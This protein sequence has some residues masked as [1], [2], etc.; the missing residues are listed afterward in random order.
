V[1][2]EAR[3][4]IPRSATARLDV[5]LVKG[6]DHRRLYERILAHIRKQGWHVLDHEPSVAERQ[7][8]GRLIGVTKVDGYNAV[9]TPVDMPLAATLA[10]V[11]ERATAGTLVKLPTLGG[12]G[13]LHY[14]DELGLP[15]IGVP[16]VNFDNNQHGPDENLRLGNFFEG[17]DILASVLLWE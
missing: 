6:N 13:P 5:R 10:G 8:Y 4:I 3:T 7:E 16:I 14:F 9:R 12:S 17:I 11:V 1:G 2:D 15:S